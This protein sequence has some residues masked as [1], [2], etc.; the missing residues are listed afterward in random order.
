MPPDW[1]S[2]ATATVE[3]SAAGYC[4]TSG[5]LSW[6]LLPAAATTVTPRCTA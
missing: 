6:W 4:G 2:V 5:G 1:E 3:S